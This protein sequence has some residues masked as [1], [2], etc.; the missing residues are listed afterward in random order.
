MKI[1]ISTE[2]INGI[3]IA[4]T[5]TILFLD[6]FDDSKLAKINIPIIDQELA[7]GKY[8]SFSFEEKFLIANAATITI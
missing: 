7:L 2:N 4:F 6:M 8:M 3:S 1:K 5:F